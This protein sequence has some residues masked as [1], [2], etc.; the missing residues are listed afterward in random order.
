LPTRSQRW[1][2]WHPVGGA[3]LPGRDPMNAAAKA[4]DEAWKKQR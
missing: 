2:I 4:R 3:K 1:S